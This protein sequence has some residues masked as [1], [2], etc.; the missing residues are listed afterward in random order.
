MRAAAG[1][2]G[3]ERGA[4]RGRHAAADVAPV[5]RH[6]QRLGPQPARLCHR[7]RLRQPARVRPP[8]AGTLCPRR[9][10]R[11]RRRPLG[12]G[13]PLNLLSSSPCFANFSQLEASFFFF[14]R[15]FLLIVF[16]VR[17][18]ILFVFCVL[19][20]N[21]HLRTRAHTSVT[22]SHLVF[23]FSFLFILSLSLSLY[24]C[25]VCVCVCVCV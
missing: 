16:F 23:V 18:S 4:G 1:H 13:R 17:T 14:F 7:P 9:R 22:V 19:N 6:A 3:K 25:F 24:N 2:G 8:G 11:R 10:R 20:K 5:P 21:K 15:S 12:P